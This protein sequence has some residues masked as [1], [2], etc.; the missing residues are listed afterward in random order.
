[1]NPISDLA[2]RVRPAVVGVVSP[3]GRGAGY[4]A[5]PNGL[6]VTSLDVVGFEREVQLVLEE[7]ATVAGVV[8]RVNVAL[9]VAL[10]LPAEA[11]SIPF[12]EAGAEPRIG[13]QTVLLGRDGAEPILFA[14]RITSTGRLGEGFP[15]I[16]L[17]W[18]FDDSLR[19]APL[20]DM[21]GG[22]LGMVVRPRRARVT[23]D[24]NAHRW[25]SGMVLPTSAFE[26]GL[27]DEPAEEL[28]EVTP[29]YGCP[30]CDTVFDAEIDRCL[31]CGTLLPHRWLRR[32]PVETPPP[33]TGLFAVRAAL[34]SL[35]IPANRARIGP[36]TWRFAPALEGQ[37]QST[38][39][40]LSVDDS[41]DHLVL[42]APLARLP[43]E[44]FENV[45]RHLLT[46]NDESSGPYRFSVVDA[47]V[48]LSLFEPVLHV[49]SATFPTTISDFARASTQY[50]GVLARHF[51]LEPLFECEPDGS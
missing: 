12:L 49:D 32:D 33:L 45:Y 2:A 30:R 27:M 38:Q 29:E 17:D 4:C 44:R 41:G 9:D 3:T 24:R 50:R 15:H 25:L 36:R 47:A 28:R 22:V 5:L 31:E 6:I 26:G 40:D 42:R 1:M 35:G 19:G 46:L 16:S 43:H 51:R 20:I 11:L 23:G 8:V 48:Y 7:G 18:T 34:A 10:V 37:E 13:D 14:P 21:Q 39:L